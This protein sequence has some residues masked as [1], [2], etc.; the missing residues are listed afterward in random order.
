M[1]PVDD[2][3]RIHLKQVLDHKLIGTG[4]KF[5]VPGLVSPGVHA[6]PSIGER[7]EVVSADTFS[8]D[9]PHGTLVF[10]CAEQDAC[11][12]GDAFGG[13]FLAFTIMFVGTIALECATVIAGGIGHDLR[14]AVREVDPSPK[15]PKLGFAFVPLFTQKVGSNPVAAIFFMVS[16][17]VP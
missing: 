9:P 8:P 12:E 17:L 2:E 1:R 11:Q 13:D 3:L 5:G 7:I 6:L 16:L 10:R 14:E 4:N 15:A